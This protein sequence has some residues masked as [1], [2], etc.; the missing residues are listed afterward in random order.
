LADTDDDQWYPP[1]TTP[2]YAKNALFQGVGK[3]VRLQPI[4]IRAISILLQAIA[5]S[6]LN[7]TYRTGVLLS[8]VNA[9]IQH[10]TGK[11]TLA[12]VRCAGVTIHARVQGKTFPHGA[13][14]A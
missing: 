8:V 14:R 10:I 1:E 9:I 6:G 12:M 11:P 7:V 4:D 13:E 3:R 2:I 5:K